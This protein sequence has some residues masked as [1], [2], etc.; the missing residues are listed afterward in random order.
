MSTPPVFAGFSAFAVFAQRLVC[1]P[2]SSY[3][4][5]NRIMRIAF[6]IVS[7]LFFLAWMIL[8]VI[9]SD[10]WIAV[11]TAVM[12]LISAAQLYLAFRERRRGSR[13]P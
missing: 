8:S 10:L 2:F 1:D 11:L 4:A 12:V 5:E 7:L 13:K 6:F 3:I 9:R